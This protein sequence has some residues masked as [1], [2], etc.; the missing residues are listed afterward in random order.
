M[1]TNK[2][3]ES[4]KKSKLTGNVSFRHTFVNMANLTVKLEDGKFV[5]TCP[6]ALGYSFAGGTTDGPGYV[7]KQIFHPTKSQELT[8]FWIIS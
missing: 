3:L 6:A 1:E 5:Q 7:L 8:Y 2:T 4:N